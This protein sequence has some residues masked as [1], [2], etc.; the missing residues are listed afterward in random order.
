MG[1]AAGAAAPCASH[2]G[3]D[4][5]PR[6]PASPGG[7]LCRLLAAVGLGA[8]ASLLP[9]LLLLPA[10][11]HCRPTPATDLG[12]AAG[13][14]TQVADDSERADSPIRRAVL[15]DWWRG[16]L[17]GVLVPASLSASISCSMFWPPLVHSNFLLMARRSCSRARWSL[18]RYFSGALAG[19]K[20]RMASRQS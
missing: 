18:R 16:C 2:P 14:P 13:V 19:M 7:I 3:A 4:R 9:R 15:H 5:E 1:F 20:R 17:H 12:S 8:L 11:V 10:G 6:S